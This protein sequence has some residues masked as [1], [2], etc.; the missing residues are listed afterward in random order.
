MGDEPRVVQGATRRS[1]LR[2]A[3]GSAWAVPVIAAAT[4]APA[5]AVGS[6]TGSIELTN[7]AGLAGSQPVANKNLAGLLVTSLTGAV[8]NNG[9]VATTGPITVTIQFPLI[10]AGLAWNLSGTGWSFASGNTINVSG[11][12]VLVWNGGSLAPGAPTTAFTLTPVLSVGVGTI[13]GTASGTDIYGHSLSN[14][15]TF[16]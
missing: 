2:I 13:T 11:Q 16:K 12:L 15:D 4:T 9:T 5:A 3:A 6:P 7:A 8:L 10:D 1:V 14:S